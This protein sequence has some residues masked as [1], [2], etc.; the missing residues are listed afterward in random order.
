MKKDKKESA[1]DIKLSDRETIRILDKNENYKYL[2][3]FGADTAKES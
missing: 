1:E 3:I 2:R